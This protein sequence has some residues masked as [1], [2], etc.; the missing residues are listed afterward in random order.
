MS[1]AWHSQQSAKKGSPSRRSMQQ[2]SHHNRSEARWSWHETQLDFANCTNGSTPFPRKSLFA[3]R[4]I[5]AR[6]GSDRFV[7]WSST[8]ALGNALNVYMHAFIFALASGRQLAVGNG[9]AIELLCGESHGAYACGLNGRGVAAQ[10]TTPPADWSNLFSGHRVVSSHNS[11]YQYQNLGAAVMKGTSAEDREFK[12][13]CIACMQRSLRCPDEANSGSGLDRESCAMVRAM[14]LLLPGGGTLRENF[15]RAAKSTAEQSWIGVPGDLDVVLKH[16][17]HIETKAYDWDRRCFFD[18]PTTRLDASTRFAGAVH[19]RALPP[20]LEGVSSQAVHDSFQGF[21]TKMN[22]TAPDGFW[23]CL[24]RNVQST[25]NAH[26]RHERHWPTSLFVASDT[27]GLCKMARDQLLTL[28]SSLPPISCMNVPPAHIVKSKRSEASIDGGL[29]SHQLTILDWHL[30]TRSRWLV[31]IGR[32]SDRCRKG[33]ARS[34]AHGVHVP[35]QSF[36]G[37]ALA[38]SGLSPPPK[39]L[40]TEGCPCQ[41]NKNTVSVWYVRQSS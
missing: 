24:A 1:V 41:V 34:G 10:R 40:N 27:D 19:I 29:D 21:L 38:A 20:A 30:L 15:A 9:V 11:W 25:E 4:T 22:T 32:I 7:T 14:Q 2:R 31:S 18:P 5:D 12:D 26:R 28:D 39:T 13:M 23:N 36:F 8:S 17:T 6:A 37:W 16:S 33:A 3:N 35:G